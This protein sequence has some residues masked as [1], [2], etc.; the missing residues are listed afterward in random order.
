MPPVAVVLVNWNG[1]AD[2]VECLDSLLTGD[3]PAFD[4]F[5]V[6]ND[7]QD[8]SVERITAWCAA[9][10][11][12]PAWR[13]LPGIRRYS[14]T[15]AR[16]VSC[17]LLDEAIVGAVPAAGSAEPAVH[18]I[19]SGANRG[20]AGGNNVGMRVAGLDRYA[21]FWLLNTDT[22]VA[23]GALRELVQR[24]LRDPGLGQV[25]STLRYYRNPDRLQ[26]MGGARMDPATTAF[27]CI[28]MDRPASE[29]PVDPTAVEQQIAYVVGASMLVSTQFVR[30]I[31]YMQED[32]FLY[33][34]EPD[35]ACRGRRQYRLGYAPD[36]VVFHKVGASSAQVASL[37]SLNL[38]YRN[39]VR[40]MTRFW[41]D[42]LRRTKRDLWRHFLHL[43]R[44]V[45]LREAMVV[46]RTL[47]DFG[48]LS[49]SVLP[50]GRS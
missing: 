29:V 4:I 2:C 22:V 32:Y 34:E 21:F 50:D 48:R 47:L 41:P 30:D 28:G 44:R 19:R 23:T 45:R 39:R 24:A 17:V 10:I 5:V 38:L 43:L 16:A 8:A 14:A 49:R 1:A 9:P 20:F 11:A 36:S 35:W 12:D 40:F 18:L 3:Y 33:F 25:G 6:D 37:W 13:E 42:R 27:W 15:D 7:S 46:A 26:A 31:G